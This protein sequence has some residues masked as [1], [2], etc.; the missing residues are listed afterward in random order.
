MKVQ[1]VNKVI[2]RSFGLFHRG[3]YHIL[4][5][6]TDGT[7]VLS[8]E[9]E[10][11]ATK[12]SIFDPSFGGG[13]KGLLNTD[14]TVIVVIEK[15]RKKAEKYARLYKKAFD[16]NVTIR[17]VKD[18]CELFPSQYCISQSLKPRTVLLKN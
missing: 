13:I 5:G 1:D 17:E 14:G 15:Y 12:W 2:R 6:S 10:V 4:G 3:D 9:L 11:I 8:K 18:Y 7:L 16:E